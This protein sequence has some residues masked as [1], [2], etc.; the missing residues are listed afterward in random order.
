MAGNSFKLAGKIKIAG[1]LFKLAGKNKNGGNLFKLAGKIK[2]AGNLLKL[3]GKFKMVSFNCRLKFRKG[4]KILKFGGEKVKILNR[5]K[6][7]KISGE[8]P[9]GD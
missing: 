3:A 5:G 6:I 8:I 7:S 2:M 1:N 9:N 4:G